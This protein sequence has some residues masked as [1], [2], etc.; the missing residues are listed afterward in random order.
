MNKLEKKQVVQILSENAF[1]SSIVLL[2]RNNGLSVRT[3]Q[4]LRRAVVGSG[5]KCVV[6]KNKLSKL[7]AKGSVYES[8]ILPLTGPNVLVYTQNDIVALTKVL[9]EFCEENNEKTAILS[10]MTDDG[11][12]LS[13]NDINQLSKLPS[14]D[15]IR[16]KIIGIVQA[17]ATKI[18]S[19]LN[20][21]AQKVV[22]VLY[23]KSVKEN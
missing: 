9:V 2:F 7:A 21:P 1:S 17:P 23:A 15:V 19:I 13:L 11:K 6:A 20:A 22:G 5:G 16:G 14:L 4:E 10:G 18:V 8:M 3:F 12:S